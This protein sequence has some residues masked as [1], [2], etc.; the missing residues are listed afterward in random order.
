ME[1]SIKQFYDPIYNFILKRVNNVQDAQDLTQEVFYKLSKSKHS[2]VDH[3]KSW[4]YTI[5]KNTITDYY[6]KKKQVM[7]DIETVGPVEDMNEKEHVISELSPCVIPFNDDLPP[8]YRRI[9]QLSEIQNQ[10][11]KQIAQALEMNY[12]TVRSRVQRGRS[13]LKSKISNCCALV[14]GKEGGIVDYQKGKDCDFC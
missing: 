10:T 7:V 14:H 11:Q 6:R 8:K 5:A 4:V 1:N 2:E 3:V 13:L 12:V 9:I